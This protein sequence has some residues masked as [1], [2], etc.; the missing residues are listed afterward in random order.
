MV[1]EDHVIMPPDDLSGND[2]FTSTIVRRSAVMNSTTININ[3][4]DVFRM[5]G[6]A[7]V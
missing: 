2:N 6:K 1:D 3:N 4:N 7:P 5:R